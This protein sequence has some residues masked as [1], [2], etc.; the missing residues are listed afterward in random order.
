MSLYASR[1][2]RWWTIDNHDRLPIHFIEPSDS[3][4][5]AERRVASPEDRHGGRGRTTSDFHM[6]TYRHELFV[7]QDPT[8][9]PNLQDVAVNAELLSD[10][11]AKFV[12][13]HHPGIRF[14]IPH[15]LLASHAKGER[16]QH[17]E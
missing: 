5:V 17:G 14:D 15:S 7:V 11:S 16:T 3:L 6:T 1:F 10:Q 4:F 9:F 2:D 13:A 8:V 12:D